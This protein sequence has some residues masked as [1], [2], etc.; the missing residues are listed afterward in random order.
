MWEKSLHR[1]SFVSTTVKIA[2]LDKGQHVSAMRKMPLWIIWTSNVSNALNYVNDL[3]LY[4]TLSDITLGKELMQYSRSSKTP[5]LRSSVLASYSRRLWN[6]LSLN[7]IASTHMHRHF[8]SKIAKR[9]RHN[10]YIMKIFRGRYVVSRD[11]VLIKS[12]KHG[13][14][15]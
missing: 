13:N 6:H 3:P 2:H 12:R 5:K 7:C 8:L 1:K 4:G 11:K 9:F 15:F 10:M 14:I